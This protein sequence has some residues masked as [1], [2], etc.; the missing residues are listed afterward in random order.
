[1]VKV[2]VKPVA[3]VTAD[4]EDANDSSDNEP[5]TPSKARA[6]PE[7]LY[8]QTS[9]IDKGNP[10]GTKKTA[11]RIELYWV[12]LLTFFKF[13]IIS[14]FTLCTLNVIIRFTWN[15]ARTASGPPLFKTQHTFPWRVKSRRC[16]ML[17][18][19]T[20]RTRRTIVNFV[21]CLAELSSGNSFCGRMLRFPQ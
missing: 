12:V 14:S 3:K 21:F 5:D 11:V 16:V 1:M 20:Q 19:T 9:K 15:T 18:A 13:E 10:S 17:G 2:P 6:R 4:D 8:K 7:T